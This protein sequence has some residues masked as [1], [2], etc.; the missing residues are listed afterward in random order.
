MHLP[1]VKEGWKISFGILGIYFAATRYV[2]CTS[3]LR[4]ALLAV[5]KSPLPTVIGSSNSY[6]VYLSGCLTWSGTKLAPAPCLAM[7]FCQ[8]LGG[9]GLPSP[10]L[11]AISSCD[12]EL[13]ENNIL[14]DSKQIPPLTIYDC[15]TSNFE[16][17][18]ELQSLQILHRKSERP[19]SMWGNSSDRAYLCNKLSVAFSSMP[20]TSVC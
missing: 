6:A 8:A 17:Y 20:S 12:T 13:H 19:L 2:I 16:V 4:A 7:C 15:A 11:D 18:I 5:P 10:E 1:D 9:R 14:Q 3:W